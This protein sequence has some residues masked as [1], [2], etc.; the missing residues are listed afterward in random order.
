MTTTTTVITHAN[1]AD[2]QP[3]E[4]ILLVGGPSSG[5]THSILSVAD[6]MQKYSPKARVYAID[7]ENGMIKLWKG[8]FSHLENLEVYMPV[9]MDGVVKSLQ[10]IEAKVTPQD[11][12]VVESISRTWDWS[13][14]LGYLTT[15][16]MKKAEFMDRRAGKS[17]KEAP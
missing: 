16:Q 4:Y 6:Y 12:I 7:T 17:I 13:Q 14:D 10:V 15:T 11:W 1:L 8:S 3:R 9:D 5:K 2:Y